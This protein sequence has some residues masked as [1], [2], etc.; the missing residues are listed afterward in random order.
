MT[1][2]RLLLLHAKIAQQVVA[3][4]TSDGK[5]WSGKVEKIEDYHVQ[6][7]LE[8]NILIHVPIAVIEEVSNPKQASR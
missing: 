2:I 5:W 6:L 7:R 1:S 4:L 8:T 3:V